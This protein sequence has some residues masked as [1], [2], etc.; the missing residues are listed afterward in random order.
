MII[1]MDGS[2]IFFGNEGS[3]GE[4]DIDGFDLEDMSKERQCGAHMVCGP[5][6]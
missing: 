5:C 2:I 4:S 3:I 1:K 6:V